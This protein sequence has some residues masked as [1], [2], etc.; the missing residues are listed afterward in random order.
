ME[1]H[2]GTGALMTSFKLTCCYFQLG[3]GAY[4]QRSILTRRQL[5]SGT[6][7][8]MTS[9]VST[10][11][12]FQ[13]GTGAYFPRSESTRYFQPGTGALMTSSVSAH[14]FCEWPLSW[15]FFQWLKIENGLAVRL[16]QQI[17][18]LE[19]YYV[20]G[21][22]KWHELFPVCMDKNCL[23]CKFLTVWYIYPRPIGRPQTTIRHT[24]LHA[25]QFAGVLEESDK[26]RKY[27]IGCQ[28][29]KKIQ[30][31]GTLFAEV[32]HPI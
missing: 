32:L 1:R 23:P 26:D 29:S 10:R 9:S 3:N 25:L 19:F 21:L 22:H 7:A 31:I 11:C 6:G 18:C 13:S 16:A 20:P 30:K 5:P 27:L 4:F 15:K 17:I 24:Y 14:P 2:T 8:L 12:Y 28:R